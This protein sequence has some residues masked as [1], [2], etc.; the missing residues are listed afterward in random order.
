MDR[1]RETIGRLLRYLLLSRQDDR[2]R[3]HPGQFGRLDRWHDI[4]NRRYQDTPV[5]QRL[6]PVSQR[7]VFDRLFVVNRIVD[8]TRRAGQFG[9]RR[10]PN[11]TLMFGRSVDGSRLELDTGT[12]FEAEGQTGTTATATDSAGRN[13]WR[14]IGGD[15]RQFE[16]R[17][18]T[19]GVATVRS[20][21]RQ[22]LS[23]HSSDGISQTLL[24]VAPLADDTFTTFERTQIDQSPRGFGDDAD[25]FQSF[26]QL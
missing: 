19:D 20:A 24:L 5:G 2:W 26:D 1:L 8:G 6:G 3:I 18:V 23:L 16:I 25:L 7:L 15:R 14:H 11:W 4:Q 12:V 21:G 13:G 9:L 17:R 10:R 22:F